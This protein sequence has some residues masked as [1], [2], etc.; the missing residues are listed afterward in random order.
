MILRKK[1]KKEEEEEEAEELE[2]L[3]GEEEQ[4]IPVEEKESPPT[5]PSEQEA[6]TG[7]PPE[8]DEIKVVLKEMQEKITRIT[9]SVDNLRRD[10]DAIREELSEKDEQI[11]KLAAIYDVVNQQIN[12]FVEEGE[13][14]KEG[15]KEEIPEIPEISEEEVKLTEEKAEEKKEI[16]EKPQEEKGPRGIL[17]PQ[18]PILE[19]IPNDFVS[20]T[21]TLRWIA[22]LLERVD[23]KHLPLLLE[24]YKDIGW[25][26]ETAK[27]QLMAYAR[28]VIQDLSYGEE[29]LVAEFGG[30]TV[31]PESEAKRQTV[32]WR[33]PAEDHIKSLIFIL[34]IKGEEIDKDLLNS[35]EM[36][37][38]KLRRSLEGY[39]GV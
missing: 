32:D 29:E 15:K 38:R 4:V 8:L 27:R 30:T 18:K 17:R 6:T 26:S 16:E 33:L 19:K 14:P 13:K 9:A 34:R 36:E 7:P 2:E 23:R 22:F 3:L 10:L 28:G 25:I 20:T 1:K 39:Y 24:Y 31:S 35:I 37:I 12:P 5:S 11:R 21:I